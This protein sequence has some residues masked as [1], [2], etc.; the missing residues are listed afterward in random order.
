MADWT[1]DPAGGGDFTTEALML[2]GVANGDTIYFAAGDHVCAGT[3]HTKSNLTYRPL[4]DGQV[5]AL[6]RTSGTGPVLSTYIGFD[7]DGGSGFVTV[8]GGT[9]YGITGNGSS[10]T[11]TLRRVTVTG[12]DVGVYRIATGSTIDQCKFH[13][14]TVEG[15]K[16][17]TG[18]AIAVT[19]SA[20][21]DNGGDGLQAVSAGNTAD[22]C[23]FYANNTAGGVAQCN[24][25]TA[26]VATECIAEDGAAIGIKAATAVRCSATDNGTDYDVSTNTDPVTGPVE[27]TD[28]AAGVFTIGPTSAAYH[29]G[30]PSA[31]V[32]DLAGVAYHAETPSIGALEG[33][34]VPTDFAVVRGIAKVWLKTAP[35]WTADAAAPSAW[36]VSGPARIGL[37]AAVA[38]NVD[39]TE[40][41]LTLD[42]PM[43][44]G[45]SYTF[46]TTAL[47]ADDSESPDLTVTGIAATAPARGTEPGELVDIQGG[48]GNTYASAA[49]GDLAKSAGLETLRKLV[50]G[51]LV[52][53]LGSVPYA[54]GYGSDLGH[55]Q[56]RPADLEDA[57]KRIARGIEQIPRVTSA[58]VTLTWDGGHLIAD[59]RVLSDLGEL[60]DLVEVV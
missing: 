58:G 54:P 3:S 41:T 52:T 42:R 11:M 9:T 47:R 39:R 24:L 15:V 13:D 12:N 4:V 6:K 50:I 25:G 56:R 46:S 17:V 2:A 38:L 35:A 49:S 51:Q 16:V 8:S 33:P 10:R 60:V 19:A 14:N 23:D 55:K 1:I 20:F 45:V 34:D 40:A 26:G 37:V 27:W 30:E 57:A 7:L 21:Y 53:I 5:W 29:A 31:V 18:Q 43:L 48:V 32:T 59:I 22:R 28:A 44:H 36:T